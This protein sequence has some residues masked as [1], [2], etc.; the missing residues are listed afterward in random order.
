[1]HRVIIPDVPDEA[2][3]AEFREVAR[4]GALVNV[5]RIMVR[6][7]QIAGLVVKLGAA[8]FRSGSLPPVDRELSILTAAKCFS[9]AYESSQH[10]QISQSVGVT[11]SQR[12]AVA[13]QQ[14]DAPELSDSQQ[15]LLA[16]VAAVA[17][18]P[19]AADP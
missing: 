1:M 11:S 18:G 10:E 17:A 5:F 19:T 2:L 14:W 15:A 3:P 8:Q 16:F 13:M 6:S 9:S 12:A 4:S 7:P